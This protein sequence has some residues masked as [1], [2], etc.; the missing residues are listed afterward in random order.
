[1]STIDRRRFLQMA[2]GAIGA[3]AA[4][5][6]L[7]ASLRRALE[8]P[9][10]RA[11]GTID[12]V[13]HVVILMQENRSF[14]HY[15]GSLR[16]VRGFGDP[17][18]LHVP[19]GMPIWQQPNAT[20]R[21][22]I[23]RARGVPDT[24]DYVLPFH[25]DTRRCGDHQ[26]GTDHSW[27][28]GH[29][30][31]NHGRSD[32]WVTQ[33][34][35][36]L[37]MGYLKR[38]DLNLHYA[39]A[40]AFTVC[41]SYFS[42]ALA[43][44]AINRIYLW[45]GTSDPRNVMGTRANGPG[46]EER[47]T[48]NGYTWTTYPER[49][50]EHGI[51]W[52]LYQGGTG[53]P[54]SPTDNFTDNSLEFFARYQLAEGADPQ[55]SLVRKGV[56]RH[57]LNELRDDVLHDRLPQ[58]S[59]IVAPFKYSEHPDA[60]AVDGG[61]YIHRVLEALTANP[62]SWSKTVLFLCYDE[63]DGL[64]DHVVP[65][66]PP[67]D[68]VQDGRGMVSAALV[69][70]LKDEFLDL[71]VH[72]SMIHPLIPG[73]DPAG[74]QPIGL[75]VRVP[76]I[77][78]SPWTTGGWVCSQTFDHTSILQFLEKRF[79]V[80]EPNISAWRRAVCG[81][82]TSA[83]DFS[84]TP[85]IAMPR[86]HAPHGHTGAVEPISIPVQQEMPVQETGSRPARAIP[87]AWTMDHRLDLAARL[88]WLDLANT[89]QA[90]AAFYV[91]DNIATDHIPRRYTVAAGDTLSDRWPL[92]DADVAYDLTAFGPNGYLCQV[93]GAHDEVTGVQ[94]G[95]EVRLRCIPQQRQ[96]AVSLRNAGASACNVKV[97]NAYGSAPASVH[98]LAPGS[99]E[100]SMWALDDSHGWY[101]IAATLVESPTYLRR[102]AGHVEDGQPSTS[103]P[104]PASSSH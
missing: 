11:S 15:F 48:T 82:L 13:E 41:D 39:L 72:T 20:Q 2:G 85:R 9:A 27:S 84:Q 97:S 42:S 90:G 51:R 19:G 101:D 46:L 57:T 74:M 88:Q 33:K 80:I 50:E 102:H 25:I 69:E 34:Q 83:F 67:P 1:M 40:D 94:P 17:R 29:L 47:H 54:G 79:G 44:T 38:Q 21:T 23:Y 8:T 56:S 63:N 45:S 95:I 104:G 76:M 86:F 22:S 92:H 78:I 26:E 43:D 5:H 3:A 55:G 36:A 70:S 61:F 24:A 62:A 10:H 89:G 12:D 91:Y 32:G 98:V 96:I 99:T 52:K 66:M 14:D 103:D 68:S 53:E 64:F 49:L 100:V 73:A 31:W 4:G 60:S 7:P 58:V 87:Y 6:A 18:P 77:V 59:W 65:P 75:G 16:G 37:T 93:R 71:D 28:S 30:A 35:D 81:D